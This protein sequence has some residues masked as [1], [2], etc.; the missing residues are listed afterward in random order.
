MSKVP[1]FLARPYIIITE[2]SDLGKA[3]ERRQSALG[4]LLQDRKSNVSVLTQPAAKRK[5]VTKSACDPK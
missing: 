5:R 3:W 4:V 2:K 1:S